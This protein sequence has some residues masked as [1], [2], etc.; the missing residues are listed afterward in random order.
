MKNAQKFELQNIKKGNNK[1]KCS[2]DLS[3]LYLQLQLKDRKD[4]IF[5]YYLQ[6]EDRSY[7]EKRV[8][9]FKMEKKRSISVY[10]F[11][12]KKSFV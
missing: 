4:K 5:H 9:T 2:S 1:D 12:D 6:T 11:Q 3:L 8:H 7:E 10:K